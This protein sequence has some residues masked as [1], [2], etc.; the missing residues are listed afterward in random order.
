MNSIPLGA[1]NKFTIAVLLVAIA[2]LPYSY[3]MF[4]RWA[5]TLSACIHIYFGFTR[6]RWAA[7]AI[8]I[9]LAVLFNPIVPVYL[10][11]V[12]W[13]ILDFLAAA[14]MAFGHKDLNKS[15]VPVN[16]K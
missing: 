15:I 13:M 7:V 12:V 10:S 1:L 6:K 11:K 14:L 8:F 5:V 16:S 9:A 4:L 3:Y 2:P